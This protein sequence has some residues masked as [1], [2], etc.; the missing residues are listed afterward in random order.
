MALLIE[1]ELPSGVRTTYHRILRCNFNFNPPK[2]YQDDGIFV[3]V[4]IEV[5]EYL[6]E[7]ARRDGRDPARR[8]VFSIPADAG[9][10]SVMSSIYAFLAKVGEE[11]DR[12]FG[13]E[14]AASA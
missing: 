8:E 5:G 3:M 2:A 10:K 14:G 11:G 12:T 7:E 1:R 9:T 4:E 6:S 13:Y